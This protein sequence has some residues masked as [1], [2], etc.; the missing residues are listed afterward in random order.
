ML[1]TMQLTVG[2]W[3]AYFL[4]AANF[5]VGAHPPLDTLLDHLR[6]LWQQPPAG[7]EV[8]TVTAWQTALTAGLLVLAT[9]TTVGR[10]VLAS[11]RARSA[12]PVWVGSSVAAMAR[13][14]GGSSDQVGSSDEEGSR[15]ETGSDSW[16]GSASDAGGGGEGVAAGDPGRVAVAEPVTL[17]TLYAR[18][19]PALS[20]RIS[21]RDLLFLLASGGVWLVPYIAGGR[22]STYRSEAFVILVVPLLRRLP[23]WLLLPVAALAAFVSWRVSVYFFDATLM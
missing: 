17:R 6:P 21:P 20:A 1:L 23:A 5:G 16:A 3:N 14:E 7:R 12:R 8:L 11:R 2:I 22:V 18:W 4:S 9:V 13:G 19:Y 15:A 10:A